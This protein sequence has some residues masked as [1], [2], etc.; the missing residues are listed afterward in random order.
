ME[1]ELEAECM[2]R[3]DGVAPRPPGLIVDTSLLDDPE[4]A[5]LVSGADDPDACFLLASEEDGLALRPPGEHDRPGVRASFP[6]DCE[7]KPGDNYVFRV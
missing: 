1:A 7:R 6:P 2:R 3:G 5:A 4:L